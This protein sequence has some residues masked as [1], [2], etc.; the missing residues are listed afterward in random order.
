MTD[1]WDLF[2]IIKLKQ[3]LFLLQR[4]VQAISEGCNGSGE[5][6]GGAAAAVL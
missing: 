2:L 3:C 6:A 1:G 5:D 4:V